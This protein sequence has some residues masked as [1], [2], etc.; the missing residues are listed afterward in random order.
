MNFVVQGGNK[1]KGEVKVQGSKNAAFPVMAACILQPGRYTIRNV[2]EILDVKNF[3]EILRYLGAKFESR[4]HI[5]SLDTNKIENKSLPKK[6]VA[7][8]RGSI[9]IAGALL[10][11][12]GRVSMAYPGGDVIGGRPIDVHLDGFRKLGAQVRENSDHLEIF[13]ERLIGSKIVLSVASVTGTENLILASVLSQG[14]TEIRLAAT[15]P[16]VQSLCLFLAKMGAKI[17]GLATP[18]LKVT[19]VQNLQ[20]VD[21]TLNSDEIETVTFCVAAAVTRGEVSVTGVDLEYLDAPLALLQKMQVN[22]ETQNGQIQISPP[23]QPYK[24]VRILTG[25]FPQLLTDDQPLFGVLATQA[26]GETSIHDW[27][28]E[29]RLGY[30]KA[31]Q[32]MGARVEFDDIHRCRIYGPS[33]LHGSEI[34]T[35]DIRAGASI[36]IAALVAKGESIIYNAEIID[37]GYE[38]LDERLNSLGAKIKRIE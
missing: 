21:F 31:L 24:A 6:L 17:E 3:L 33:P 38:R 10:G 30:L 12:F 20:P 19:G 11:R 34:V 2:P 8:L 9:V 1:L 15:E 36:L 16:H 32:A 14:V 29:G 35:P 7:K 5:L 13:A 23:K 25:V 4:N 27:I 37:R 26:E 18:Y 28:Y 22:L